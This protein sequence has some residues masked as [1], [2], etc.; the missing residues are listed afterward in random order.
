MSLHLGIDAVNIRGGGGHTHLIELLSVADP[1][2]HDFSCITVFATLATLAKL[3]DRPWLKKV[4]TPW[5]EGPLWRRVWGQYAFMGSLARSTGCDVLF[6]PGA[7]YPFRPKMPVITLSQNMLP[8]EPKEAARFGRWSWMRLKMALL[9][10]SQTRAF[11]QS[12]GVIFLTDYAHRTT[13][14]AIGQLNQ[15]TTVIPHGIAPRFFDR[16]PLPSSE[17]NHPSEKPHFRL[18][19][20]SI[21]LPYKHQD[22]VARA[23]KEL[24]HSGLPVTA[25]FVGDAGTSY[26]QE[27]QKLFHILDPERKMLN[28][29]G[30]LSFEELH[31]EYH[32]ADGFVFAS[33]CENLPNILLEA[34]AAGLPI[35]CAKRGPMPEVLQDYGIYFDP[36][37]VTSIVHALRS[38]TDMSIK[39]LSKAEEA[40]NF[41][42][43]FTWGACADHTLAFIARVAQSAT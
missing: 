21:F 18:L 30:N 17:N 23:V 37:D 40:Q 26:G 27:C 35:A 29:R 31:H 16:P 24:N 2:K 34:M 39:G 19:Y 5:M 3:P 9:R 38:L 8:F 25:D 10:I 4:S 7:T 20:V 13:S 1:L 15:A 6:T 12:D 43:S 11:Q 32:Q 33:S 28:V 41:A 36:E 42:R 14:A 22:Q